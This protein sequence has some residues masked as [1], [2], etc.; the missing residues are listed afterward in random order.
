MSLMVVIKMGVAL[1]LVGSLRLRI[2]EAP[3]RNMIETIEGK[4]TPPRAVLDIRI[5]AR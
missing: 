3:R 4:T 5:G 2:A 1:V